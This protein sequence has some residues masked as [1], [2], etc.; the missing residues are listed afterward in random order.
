MEVIDKLAW[1]YIQDRKVLF[2]REKGKDAFYSPGGQREAGE[3]DEQALTREIKEELSVD[4]VP[5]TIKYAHTFTAQAHGK[6]EGVMVEIKYYTG[7]F[8]GDLQPASE[9]EELAYFQSS[10]AHK[11]SATGIL[12]LQWL[13]EQHVID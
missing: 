12:F 10:D 8:V 7:D 3:T 6:P 2:V 13:R 11:T 4:L 9:I 1:M 5:E